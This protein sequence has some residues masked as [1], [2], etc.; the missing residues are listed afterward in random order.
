MT[1]K[2]ENPEL[3][4]YKIILLSW[5][6]IWWWDEWLKIGWI[7]NPIVKNPIS[8]E[9]YIPWSSIKWKMRSSL[10]MIKWDYLS[11]TTTNSIEYWPS[12]NPDN[13]SKI[14]R[15]FWMASKK[16]K[17][18]SRLIFSDFELTQEYKKKFAELWLTEFMELKSENTIPRFLS[19]DAKPRI[20]ERVPAWVEFEWSITLVPVTWDKE[21]YPVSIDDLEKILEEGIKYLESFWLWW[22]VSRWNWRIKFEK[23]S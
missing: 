14:A 3:R 10:E 2:I 4:K 12:E 9:P 11:K 13:D 19:W 16:M 20:I 23:I 18:S 22:W 6:H 5:L 7:D 17:I 21:I 15:S 8:W 1:A